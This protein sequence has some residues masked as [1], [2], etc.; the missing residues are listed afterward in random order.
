[1]NFL[2]GLFGTSEP[3]MDS[4]YD[5]PDAHDAYTNSQRPPLR[6][7]IANGITKQINE[8]RCYYYH[9]SRTPLSKAVG[10]HLESKNYR[11]LE[12]YPP[13]SAYFYKITWNFPKE[14]NQDPEDRP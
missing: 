7:E 1:M 12:F 3:V 13:E 11:I 8:G 2:R 5:L 6:H 10:D 9:I 14:Q 4:I